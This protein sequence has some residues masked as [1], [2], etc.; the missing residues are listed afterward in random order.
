MFRL[1]C[2]AFLIFAVP[3]SLLA[4][5]SG[6]IDVTKEAFPYAGPVGH[7]VTY[8]VIVTNATDCTL[9]LDHAED[10][11][12]GDVTGYFAAELEPSASNS[13]EFVHV[14]EAGDPDPLENVVWFIYSDDSGAVYE[15]AGAAVVD[16][17]NPDFAV[18][19]SCEIPPEP[20]MDV[21]FVLTV[22]NGGDVP[23]YFEFSGTPGLP[24]PITLGPGE[25]AMAFF[26]VPC[27]GDMACAEAY[28]TATFPP[29]YGLEY[30]YDQH[31]EHCCPCQGSPV[32]HETWGVIKALYRN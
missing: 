10:T 2:V 1:L 30:V 19:L 28:V 18:T 7:V 3:A 31:V 17:L 25:T 13:H 15:G 22:L 14:I 26:S 29:E 23:L 4:Q 32:E 12:F 21:E 11:M 16:V 9:Y 6:F 8:E 24:T 27:E 20:G 5:C